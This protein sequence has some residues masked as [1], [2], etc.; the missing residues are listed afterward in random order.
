MKVS[1]ISWIV[2]IAS[3]LGVFLFPSLLE[4]PYGAGFAFAFLSFFLAIVSLITALFFAKL[5]KEEQKMKSKIDL[6]AHWIYPREFWLDFARE[7]YQAQKS[8]KLSI[9]WII[10]FFCALFG[11]LFPLFDW[12]NGL[13]VT[14]VCFG[15]GLLMTFVA[16]LSIRYSHNLL[17]A[18]PKDKNKEPEVYISS[19]GVCFNG[20][21]HCWTLFGSR[22]DSA[23]YDPK[24]HLL[25][26]VYSYISR[27]EGRHYQELRIPVPLDKETEAED[28]ALK[29]SQL[30]IKS[31]KK[32]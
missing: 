7:E 10:L 8:E 5:E 1:A 13:I 15:L 19:E 26:I 21:M 32:K 30:R 17:F 14:G 12:E 9:L 23:D 22:F 2:F 11:V 18:R 25:R 24:E 28:L 20:E 29:L 6:L 3:V 4:E 31:K 27:A 16:F